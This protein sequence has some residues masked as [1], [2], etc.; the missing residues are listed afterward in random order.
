MNIFV[1]SK[2]P[3]IAAHLHCDKHVVKM[4]LETAQLLY[5][6]HPVIPGGYKRTH[7]N[8]PCAVWKCGKKP[9]SAYNVHCQMWSYK[10]DFN[11]R[12]CIDRRST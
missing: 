8:H 6:A 12:R 7:V 9:L 1:L 10:N 3:Q 4:I 11:T 2:N 5:S